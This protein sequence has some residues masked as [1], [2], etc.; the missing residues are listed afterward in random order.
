M[1][2]KKEQVGYFSTPD[3]K[4][5]KEG[6]LSATSSLSEETLKVLKGSEGGISGGI[7]DDKYMKELLHS[8]DRKESSFSQ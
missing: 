7:V 2:E 5:P 6:G 1:E 4:K 3:S 8:F